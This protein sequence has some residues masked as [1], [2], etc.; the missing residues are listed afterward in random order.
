MQVGL[1]P[2]HIVLD[3]AQLPLPQKGT[4]P[5]FGPYMLWPTGWITIIITITITITIIIIQHL[6]SA[7]K[8]CKG[9]G[10]AWYRGRPRPKRHCVTWGPRSPLPKRG[11]NFRPMS[12]WSNSWMDQDATWY[13]GRPRP[14]PHCA[15]WGSSL[16]Q[17][18]YIPQ[19]SAHVHCG[20]TVAHLSYC[21]H[22]LPN[23]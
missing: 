7:L 22:S 20:Q 5:I 14:W 21:W 8:S 18:G 4:P 6:Y 17:K 3:G 10:G 13:G 1:S 9:Y 23:F 16:P 15:R 2:G 12:T 19:F 11:Q